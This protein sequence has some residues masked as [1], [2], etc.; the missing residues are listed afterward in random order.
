MELGFQKNTQ[1]PFAAGHQLGQVP[2]VSINKGIKIISLDAAHDLGKSLN[3]LVPVGIDNL[4]K[5]GF[6]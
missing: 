3:D 2:G 5:A 1:R 6:S 4:L